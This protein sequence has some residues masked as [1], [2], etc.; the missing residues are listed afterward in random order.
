[1]LARHGNDSGAARRPALMTLEMLDESS[2]ILP[3]ASRRHEFRLPGLHPRRAVRLE[4]SKDRVAPR[5]LKSVG[6]LSRRARSRPSA[7]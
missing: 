7:F 3:P 4:V 5:S 6:Q 2:L 1:M